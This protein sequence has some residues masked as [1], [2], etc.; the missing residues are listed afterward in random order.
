MTPKRQ[1]RIPWLLRSCLLLL[2]GLASC[3]KYERVKLELVDG[4]QNNEQ[5]NFKATEERKLHYAL[6]SSGKLDLAEV[7]VQSDDT[8]ISGVYETRDSAGFC[9]VAVTLR[10]SKTPGG[11]HPVRITFINRDDA[12]VERNVTLNILNFA[13]LLRDSTLR[14][15]VIDTISSAPFSAERGRK[16]QY[17]LKITQLRT[18][19]PNRFIFSTLGVNDGS[20]SGF[21]DDV[22]VDIDSIS[23]EMKA[24][25]QVGLPTYNGRGWLHVNDQSN[26]VGAYYIYRYESG[27]GSTFEGHLS[28]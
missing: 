17:S 28:F 4:R 24:G 3:K 6:S 18:D 13:Q 10:T 23:G 12:F 22:I 15:K 2:A 27:P 16:F 21:I 11:A 1:T 26:L 5:L 20:G 8:S 9:A 7:R 25:G 14:Y 19:P